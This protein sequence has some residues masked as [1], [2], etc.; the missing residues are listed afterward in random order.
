MRLLSI[1][2]LA[3]LLLACGA[4]SPATR[5][6]RSAAPTDADYAAH[7]R[8]L[9]QKLA[10]DAP[11]TRFTLLVQKPFIV[12]GDAPA[13]EVR[14]SAART[15]QWAVDHLKKD[16]FD[17]DPP[18]ILDIYLFRDK[19]SYD[20]HTRLLFNDSPT[21]PFG[22]YS[23]AH[24]ALI[25]NI[26]TGGGTLVHEIVHPFVAANFPECPSWFNEGLGSLFEQCDDREG[27][28]VGLT[29]WRLAGLQAALRAGK[30]P[31]FKTL[32]STTTQEFYGDTRGT[33][34]A[35]ARY[36]LYYLQQ[37][38]LLRPYYRAFVKNQKDDPTGYATLLETLKVK[39]A[40]AADFQKQWEQWV[41]ALRFP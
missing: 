12:I 7:L 29:N 3:V 9:Q 17:T 35:Q 1:G 14:A 40:D 21:T 38:N 28:I 22:Y 24:K 27:H 41:L 15:V 23:P 26:A 5:P 10:K 8:T 6:G 18:D 36:L 37:K 32:L 16:F 39:E 30:V 11:D 13:D 2:T 31:P 19:P 34:Y 4:S 33:N 20:T 25:M